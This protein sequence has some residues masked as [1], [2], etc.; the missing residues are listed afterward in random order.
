MAAVDKGDER[1]A[2]IQLEKSTRTD[3]WRIYIIRASGYGREMGK[4]RHDFNVVI[5]RCPA[6]ATSDNISEKPQYSCIYAG[7]K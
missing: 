6:L 2:I 5:Q 7:K 3:L 4:V 1:R